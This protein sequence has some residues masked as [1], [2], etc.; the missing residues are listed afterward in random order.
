MIADN[1]RMDAYSE[2]LRLAVKPDSIVLDIGAGTGVFALLACQFGA[3]RVYA[4]ESADAIQIAREIAAANGYAD[5]IEFI[6]KLST[7]VTLPERA[8]IVISDLRG[9]LPF[10]GRHISSIADARA[11]LLKP[12]GTLIS[13]R[14]DVWA[15]IVD[16]EETYN[17]HLGHWDKYEF[18]MTAARRIVTNTIGWKIRK[19]GAEILL[20]EPGLWATLDYTTVSDPNVA[21]EMIFDVRRDGTAH[22]MLIWFDAM[23]ADGVGFSNAPGAENPSK[24]YGR[25][26]FPWP[27]PVELKE[28]DRIDARL[29]ARLVGDDYV[30]RWETTVK[31]R[32]S[33]Q[34]KA[35]FN[36]STFYG[37]SLSLNGLCKQ[38]AAYVPELNPDGVMDHYI[39]GRLGA[40]TPLGEIAKQLA[41]R[42]PHKFSRWQDALTHVGKLSRKYS[43]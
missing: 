27:Q 38:G 22:G 12:G 4:I 6:Q 2:A 5:R 43:E 15:A 17:E 33:G 20:A 24:V 7:D 26:F 9:R 13:R 1:A 16:A 35:C 32:N 18:D 10:L 41:E 37:E 8:D 39:L 34:V 3:R 19:D 28:G 42:F 40:R 29:E 11:R 25:S 23:T 21:G 31:S 30:Y 14:D 36:Q